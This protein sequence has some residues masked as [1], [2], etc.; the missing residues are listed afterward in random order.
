MMKIKDFNELINNNLMFDNEIELT[1][2]IN[3]NWDDLDK[4]WNDIKVKIRHE[5]CLKYS[6]P[7]KNAIKVFS[8]L[9]TKKISK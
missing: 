9:L 5:F 8:D 6:I 4:W 3:K 1:K 7:P 2:F